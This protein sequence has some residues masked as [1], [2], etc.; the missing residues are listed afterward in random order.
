V[1]LA[2]LLSAAI[3]N[4]RSWTTNG[5]RERRVNKNSYIQT[6]TGKQI[7]PI[8]PDPKDI[9]IEDIAHALSNQCRWTGHVREFYSVA[10]HCILGSYYAPLGHKLPFLLHD[11]S[12]AYLSDVARPIK[13]QQEFKI[14]R[15]IEGRLLYAIETVFK[16]PHGILECSTIKN[17]DKRMLHTEWRDLINDFNKESK[18]DRDWANDP[19]EDRIVYCMQPKDAE[20]KY[21]ELFY[22][23]RKEECWKT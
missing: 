1:G 10:N 11:A 15:E 17:I 20:Q 22:E 13:Q 8:M 2:M 4:K 23:Y 5:S 14:Y 18:I 12:E 21:L 7:T 6:F 3:E 19:Y 9:C 16:L